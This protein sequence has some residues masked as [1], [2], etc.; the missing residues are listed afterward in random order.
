MMTLDL[1]SCECLQTQ[2]P[3]AK[4]RVSM[5][6][7]VRS[8]V[9][10]TCVARRLPGLQCN[11]RGRPWLYAVR[12]LRSATIACCSY[13]GRSQLSRSWRNSS[14]AQRGLWFVFHVL[15]YPCT[16]LCNSDLMLGGAVHV[17][18]AFNLQ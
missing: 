9:R 13:H 12:C 3:L 15:I 2:V 11:L 17:S 10:R 1:N 18:Y 4:L 6:Q 8:I 16:C 14:P 7:S 5:L